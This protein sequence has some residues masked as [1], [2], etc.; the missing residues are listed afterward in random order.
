MEAKKEG[1]YS[2][3]GLS[4]L[5]TIFVMRER[6]ES[7]QA[8]YE[9]I[10]RSKSTVS[11]ALN[12]YRHPSW[13][14]WTDMSPIERAR[15]VYE[16]QQETRERIY[17][18]RSRIKDA[19]I[20]EYVLNKLIVEH[21]SPESIAGRIS[22]DRPG[23]TI[24]TKTIYN[25]IK[26]ERKDLVTY[27]AERGK[28]RRQRV[29]HRR[30]RLKQGA[31]KK[32]SIDERPP[33]IE[34]RKEVGHWEGDT[35]VGKKKRRG[36]VLSLRERTTKER[37]F[38]RIPD[39]T[40]SG[41]LS[42][43]RGFLENLPQEMRKSITLDNGSEFAFSELIKLETLYPG[44]KLYY[45]DPYQAWQKG[46]VE[47]SHRGFRWYFPKGTDFS[48]IRREDIKR[49]EQKLNNRPMKCHDFRTSTEVFEESLK[50]MDA[51]A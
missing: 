18:G 37:Y 20:R 9:R 8:I 1:Y 46:C 33:E 7:I 23:K 13:K 43:L 39:L 4:E 10:G 26:H 15:H 30:G 29:M 31:P 28:P 11:E 48:T 41:M 16:R 12:K 14:V 45:C 22:I 17:K 42:A 2:R 34:E 51:A 47:N 50:H 19:Q 35:V 36:A 25:Y 21:W 49:I 5:E 27:L 3:L 6:K 44:L 38:C 40:A 32:R 24:S